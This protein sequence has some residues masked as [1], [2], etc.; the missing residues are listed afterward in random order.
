MKRIFVLIFVFLTIFVIFNTGCTFYLCG[1][2]IDGCGECAC[3]AYEAC[4][5]LNCGTNQITK[6]WEEMS[7]AAKEGVDYSKPILI[8]E[9]DGVNNDFKMD[10]TAHKSFVLT[11]EICFMQDGVLLYTINELQTIKP[12]PFVYSRYLYL[13]NYKSNGGEVYCFINKF[14]ARLV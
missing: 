6:G 1:S 13:D 4:A 5:S 11:F 12:G 9:S 10:F 14:E 2:G 7:F 8:L 3:T